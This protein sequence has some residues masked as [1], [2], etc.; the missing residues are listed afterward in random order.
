[1]AIYWLLP[2]LFPWKPVNTAFPCVYSKGIWACKTAT[3]I[4]TAMSKK[5]EIITLLKKMQTYLVM[6]MIIQYNYC[7]HIFEGCVWAGVDKK[8]QC[9]LWQCHE[10]SLSYSFMTHL[11]YVTEKIH[12]ILSPLLETYKEFK[13]IIVH[14]TIL[15]INYS[16]LNMNSLKLWANFPL[17]PKLPKHREH[18]SSISAEATDVLGHTAYLRH[19]VKHTAAE[20]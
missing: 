16:C 14:K 3:Y 6:H 1:M 10:S 7:M 2:A 11:C 19:V 20:I 17:Q 18:R 15:Y 8:S 4:P 5:Q 13:V 12:Y 9:Y